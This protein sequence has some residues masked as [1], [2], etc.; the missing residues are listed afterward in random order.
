MPKPKKWGK[1][2]GWPKGEFGEDAAWTSFHLHEDFHFDDPEDKRWTAPQGTT[3]DGASIPKPFWSFIGGPYAGKYFRAS[4]IHDH[5]V[6]VRTE[7][8][9]ATH[10]NFYC[11]MRAGGVAKWKAK[12]MYWAVNTFGPQWKTEKRVVYHQR[13]HSEPGAKPVLMVQPEWSEETVALPRPDLEDPRQLAAALAKFA[14]VA[15]TLKTTGG[16]VLDIGPS[17]AISADLDSIVQNADF[18]AQALLVARPDALLQDLGLA[19]DWKGMTL[20][21]LEPWPDGALPR[22][23]D[24]VRPAQKGLHDQIAMPTREDIAHATAHGAAFIL[25]RETLN[26]MARDFD[27]PGFAMPAP[28]L[29]K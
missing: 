7:T 26:G 9:A 21:T 4:V 16:E 5:Y 14:A 22:Y 12:A 19:T 11:G 8:A 28:S 18:L 25:D 17:G 1:F 10:L 29:P 24:L 13:L 27:D 3:V 15:R 6:V 23:E 2:S 20:D